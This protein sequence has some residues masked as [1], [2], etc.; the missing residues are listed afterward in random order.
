MARLQ[1]ASIRLVQK[2]NRQNKN[3]ENPIYVVVCFKGRKEKACG[4][5]CLP[6][7]W[8]SRRELIKGGC[9]NAPVLN[10]M[11]MDIKQRVIER[12]TFY[13]LNGKVY[14]PQLLLEDSVMDLD[15]RKN[16][17]VSLM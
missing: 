15:G 5:S 7:Y 3:G 10:K 2:M 14:T 11:L 8:D 6:R 17:F 9:P 13:E 16:V 4:I 1:S 12:K